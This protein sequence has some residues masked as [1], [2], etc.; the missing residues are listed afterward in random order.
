MRLERGAAPRAVVVFGVAG[1][2]KTSAARR[3]AERMGAAFA[4][5]DDYHDRRLIAQMSAGIPLEDED[6]WEWLWRLRGLTDA[7]LQR[8]ESIVLACSALKTAYRDILRGD[9]ADTIFVELALPRVALQRRIAARTGHFMPAS[10]LDSQLMSF[11]PLT[12]AE[13]AGGSFV[14]SA[15]SGVDDV[16][17]EIIAHLDA[18]IRR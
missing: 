17:D 1:V 5:A 18:G 7:A 13:R 2:G 9:G 12:E 4:D 16:A 14:V 10:M 11:E 3:L 15:A 8:G 6:R